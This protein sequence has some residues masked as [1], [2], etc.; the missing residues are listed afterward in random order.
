MKI[1]LVTD[2]FYFAN[3]GMTISSRRLAA[4]LAEHGHEVRV[5]TAGLTKDGERKEGIDGMYDP[6]LL[7]E[8]H[9]PV[10]DKLITSQ[11][12]LFAGCDDAVIEQA[13]CWADMIHILVPFVVSHHVIKMARKHNVP[14]TGAFHVQP[15]NIT[16]SI[17]MG[18]LNWINSILYRGFHAYIYRYLPHIH[19]PSNFIAG[20]L[21]KHG[22]REKIHVISNGI[23]PD[24]SYRKLPK[25]KDLEGKFVVLM[26]GRL[27]IEK[28]QDV[29]IRA[30]A[31]S[32]HASKIQLVL[33]GNGPRKDAL[34]KLARKLPNPV[35]IRFFEK[36]E[37]QDMIAM[38]DLYVHAADMEIEAMSCM[39]AFAS[40]LV[41]VIAD[42][43]KSATPQFA[44][45]A[46][47]LFPAGDSTALARR[48]DYWFEHEQERRE[49][50]VRYSEL[51]KRYALEDCVR[52]MEEMFE[53][54]IREM[55]Q[56]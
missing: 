41:P 34:L 22:Y 35:Q 18:N 50:E 51:G 30:V 49:M 16:S 45:D 43:H 39:E 37:L 54:A 56:V 9:L 26:I 12:M 24:F 40:G 44:L 6:F 7:P 2:Q 53:Q 55:G 19:C 15:E 23:D 10:F 11:G 8:Y 5:L 1:L 17:H 28:R 27:S 42:S 4:V 13:V 38:S 20:E 33:A 32:S 31:K 21:M 25:T 14:M 3:N 48:I 46:R 36:S 29:L 52:R 47:S